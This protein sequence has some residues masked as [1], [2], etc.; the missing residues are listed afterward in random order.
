[1]ENP[2]GNVKIKMMVDVDGV[3]NSIVE[4]EDESQKELKIKSEDAD[5]DLAVLKNSVHGIEVR[6]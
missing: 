6:L 1:M 3:L 5:V 2:E 4:F